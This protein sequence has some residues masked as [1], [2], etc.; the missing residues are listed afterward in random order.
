VT[1][2]TK[3]LVMRAERRAMPGVE[4][5]GTHQLFRHPYFSVES[6]DLGP[7]PAHHIRAEMLYVGV[8]GTD[9][10]LGVTDHET[11]YVRSSS[12]LTLDDD[13]RILG[14][15][16]LGRVLEVGEGVEGIAR[17]GV[18]TFESIIRCHLCAPCRRGAF[19]QCERSLLVG[20]ET[21]GLFRTVVDVPA[22]LAHD[23]SD[24]EGEESALRGAACAEPAACAH[25]ACSLAGL[26][27]GDDV[28]VFG[29]GPIG[30]FATMLARVAFGAETIHVVEPVPFRR[31]LAGRWADLVYDP[32]EFF[33]ERPRGLDVVIETSGA[34]GQIDQTIPLLG[35][36]SRIALLARGVE[37][38][39]I[40]R[41]DRIITNNISIV[42]SRGHLGGAF[43]AVLSLLRTGMLPLDQAVTEVITGLDELRDR[44]AAPDEIVERNCKLLA[45]LAS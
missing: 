20:A 38:F 27:A 7:L 43:E 19:N 14:H 41:V 42:G 4:Y 37:P 25:L 5:P 1:T 6:R 22:M 24:L 9:V 13:G 34:L 2:S 26:R 18:V 44:L 40:E 17:G 32:D 31:K 30:L 28:V 11:G 23:V 16:G 36:N 3:A 29:A 15:E 10:H 8:C 21:D 39:S 35:A 45:R 33:A 12:P